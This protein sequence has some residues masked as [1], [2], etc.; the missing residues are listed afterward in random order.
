MNFYYKILLNLHRKPT[1]INRPFSSTLAFHFPQSICKKHRVGDSG[2][3]NCTDSIWTGLDMVYD[4][5]EDL[6]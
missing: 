4:D 6:D 1:A 2:Q 3:Y 5:H